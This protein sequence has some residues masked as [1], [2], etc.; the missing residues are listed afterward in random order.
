MSRVTISADLTERR[1]SRSCVYTSLG[2]LWRVVISA[3]A[4]AASDAPS[5]PLVLPRAVEEPVA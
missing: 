1:D 3:T 4:A 5:G 2:R